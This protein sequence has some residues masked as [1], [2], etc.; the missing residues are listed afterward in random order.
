[1][2]IQVLVGL[3]IPVTVVDTGQNA[4]KDMGTVLQQDIKA[5]PELW[6]ANF[7]GVA[8]AHGGNDIAEQQAAFEKGKLAV[9]FELVK[10]PEVV[11]KAK[12]PKGF[13]GEQALVSQVVDSEYRCW[14]ALVITEQHRN[15]AGLPIVTVHNVRDRKSTR[16]NSSHVRISYA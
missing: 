9:E 2:E 14:R 7:P 5:V 16:L 3:R 10:S 12:G 8:R 13:V 6:R 4:G 15:Q 1:M 11:R